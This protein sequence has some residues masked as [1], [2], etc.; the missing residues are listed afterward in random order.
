MSRGRHL[1][2]EKREDIDQSDPFAPVSPS[3]MRRYKT[4]HTRIVLTAE[5]LS[6]YDCVVLAINHEAFI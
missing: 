6:L 4:E 1:L 5:V 2:I 3:S